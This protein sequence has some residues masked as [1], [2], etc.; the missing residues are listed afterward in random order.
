[1]NVA[2]K[3]VYVMKDYVRWAR[4]KKV[5]AG[6]KLGNKARGYLLKHYIKYYIYVNKE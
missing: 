5:C 3:Q 4:R 1:M 2:V 6:H